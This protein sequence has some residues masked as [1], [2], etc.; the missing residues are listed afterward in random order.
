MLIMWVME[1]VQGANINSTYHD[2]QT[3]E[4]YD[5]PLACAR[6]EVLPEDEYVLDT[7]L[8][9]DGLLFARPLSFLLLLVS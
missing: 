4:R 9:F 1:W 3:P 8:G 5:S 6:T 2:T 7:L